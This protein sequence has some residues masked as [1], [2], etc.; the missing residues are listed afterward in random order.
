MEKY[1]HQINLCIDTDPDRTQDSLDLKQWIQL[2]SD[3]T[4][5]T[6]N[7]NYA[8]HDDHPPQQPNS[9]FYKIMKRYNINQNSDSISK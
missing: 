5:I 6:I 3:N 9:T 7:E 1:D 2:D 8:I 4:P